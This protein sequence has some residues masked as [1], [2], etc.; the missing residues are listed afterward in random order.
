MFNLFPASFYTAGIVSDLLR[1]RAAMG[2]DTPG[3]LVLWANAAGIIF[4]SRQ[5]VENGGIIVSGQSALGSNYPVD[6]ATRAEIRSRIG[7]TSIE[8][9][10]N[11]GIIA[12]GMINSKSPPTWATSPITRDSV[13]QVSVPGAASIQSSVASMW[14][15][16][17]FPI[18]EKVMPPSIKSD[19]VG[20]LDMGFLVLPGTSDPEGYEAKAPSWLPDDN[21]KQAW[22]TIAK[23]VNPIAM[24]FLK[25]AFEQA[26]RDTAI[27]AANA[28]FWDIATRIVGAI[29]TMGVSELVTLIQG[30]LLVK[31]REYK[32]QRAAA[33]VVIATKPKQEADVF[34]AQLAEKDGKIRSELRNLS[35]LVGNL[36]KE[37][38]SQGLGAYQLYIAA[39]AVVLAAPIV[40]LLLKLLSDV[41][42]FLK[43]FTAGAAS[44]AK[45]LG[46][47]AAVIALGIGAFWLYGK[48]KKSTA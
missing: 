3:S 37:L 12:G 45:P 25:R 34:L 10:L 22:L 27:T 11:Y 33:M 23:E 39:G 46:A 41:V 32:K 30:D 42:D 17:I 5:K 1:Q 48:A 40:Y 19:I 28:K 38:D 29:A 47:V 7:C 24:S 43:I 13:A 36:D 8:P 2:K 20:L 21:Y 9:Q 44:V 4:P 14:M 26:A 6:A 18:F 31:L 16:R 35:P 15:N